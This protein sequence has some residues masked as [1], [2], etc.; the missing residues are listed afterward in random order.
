MKIVSLGV[1]KSD[2]FKPIMV[3]ESAKNF[4]LYGRDKTSA[5]P[6]R[7]EGWAVLKMMRH[8]VLTSY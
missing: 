4:Y 8:I 3:P 6:N 5:Q 1:E 7:L 2:G